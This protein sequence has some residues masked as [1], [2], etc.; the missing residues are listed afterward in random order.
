[1]DEGLKVKIVYL[2]NRLGIRI[3]REAKISKVK[4]IDNFIKVKITT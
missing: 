4:K 1:M 2:D 3:V